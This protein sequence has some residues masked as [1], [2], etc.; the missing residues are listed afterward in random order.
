[1]ACDERYA[2]P[3]AVA[4]SSIARHSTRT[5]KFV[6][7]VDGV[8]RRSIERIRRVAD[9][10]GAKAIEFRD[11]SLDHYRGIAVGRKHLSAAAFVR[12]NLAQKLQDVPRVI[13][14]DCD[15]LCLRDIAAL[16][17]HPCD[18]TIAAVRDPFVPMVGSADAISYA[19]DQEDCDTL[20]LRYF[21]SGVMIMDLVRWTLERADDTVIAFIARFDQQLN[22]ADQDVLNWVFLNRW[23]QLPYV[24]NDQGNA[25]LR[26]LEGI[27]DLSPIEAAWREALR[28]EKTV[29]H[30]TGPVK[31]W[32]SGVR[33]KDAALWMEYALKSGYYGRAA[34]TLWRLRRYFMALRGAV[35]NWLQHRGQHRLSRW[36]HR[37]TC[38]QQ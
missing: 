28:C 35:G 37:G 27:A 36:L 7:F 13:W 26:S 17:A 21:N 3:L 15:V 30:F 31:P 29:R 12:L 2:F 34:M 32:L 16:W 1:M 18:S 33:D 20:R 25:A 38:F 11:A 8:K 5:V 24:W 14:M 23:E 4:V 10:A 22:A 9:K 6:V 19:F